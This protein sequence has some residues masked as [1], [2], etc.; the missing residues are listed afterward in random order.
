LR[1]NRV[2]A[3]SIGARAAVTVGNSGVEAV[4]RIATAD[5]QPSLELAFAR[6]SPDLTWRLGAYRRLAPVDPATRALG[7]GNSLG[8]L[9]LGRDDGDYFRAA[10]VDLTVAPSLSAPQHFT[11]RIYAEHQFVARRETELSVAHLFRSSRVFRENITADRADEIGTQLTLR[12]AHP[13]A[14]GRGNLGLDAIMDVSAGT[15]AFG[16]LALTARATGPLLLGLVGALEA[17]GGTTAGDVPRQ[18]RWYLGG[19]ATLRGYAGD[20]ADGDAFWR[21]RAEVANAF[22]AARIALFADAGWAG[23][24]QDAFRIHPLL[25]A[26][27]GVSFLDGMVRLDLAR[28]LR[29]PKGWR[30]ELYSDAAL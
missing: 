15:F 18:S 19:S 24:R 8:A 22:P 20:A 17:A 3:L 23:A 28:A 12:G 16:R 26:G 1:Y 7:F 25:S 14:E 21:G 11:W 13:F 4:A 10:G 5:W 2:E 30:L 29:N 27:I 9:L 6:E